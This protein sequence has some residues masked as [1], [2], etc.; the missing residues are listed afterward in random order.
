MLDYEDQISDYLKANFTPSDS[1]KSNFNQTTRELLSF[2]FRTFPNDCISDYQLNSILL[3][4]G[5]E[6]HNVLVEHTVECEEGKGKEK[7]KFFRIEK[8]IEFSWCMRSPFNLEPE[9]IDR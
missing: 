1:N 3:E 9:I 5:Y 4:L 7:R 2:L 8:H 6:R